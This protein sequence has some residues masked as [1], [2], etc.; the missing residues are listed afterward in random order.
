MPRQIVPTQVE[1]RDTARK[2]AF[3]RASDRSEPLGLGARADDVIEVAFARVHA[4]DAV[5]A[6][7]PIA[8]IVQEV[9][10]SRLFGDVPIGIVEPMLAAQRLVDGDQRIACGCMRREQTAHFGG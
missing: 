7:L 10:S 2:A 6:L 9:I 3:A 5:P 8:R 4:S 1:R